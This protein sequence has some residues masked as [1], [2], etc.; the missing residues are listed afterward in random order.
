MVA[1]L[2]ISPSL[3]AEERVAAHDVARGFGVALVEVHTHDL[4]CIVERAA[5][6]VRRTPDRGV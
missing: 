5:P 1:I 3:P 6:R 2:G 4:L